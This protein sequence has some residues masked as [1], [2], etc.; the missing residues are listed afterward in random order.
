M[1]TS[2]RIVDSLRDQ[3]GGQRLQNRA[4]RCR[5]G[6]KLVGLGPANDGNKHV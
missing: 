2:D 5:T 4:E 1:S 6:V 3:R